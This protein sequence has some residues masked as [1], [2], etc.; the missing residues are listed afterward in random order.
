M[1]QPSVDPVHPYRGWVEHAAD[2]LI[3]G[4]WRRY[5]EQLL[6]LAVGGWNTLF[7][8]LVFVVLYAVGHGAVS[9]VAMIVVSWVISIANAYLGYRYVVFR[10]H[11]RVISELPR[12]SL[13]YLVSMAVNLVVLP[14]AVRTLPVNPYVVQG[15]FTVCVVVA[16]YAG[17]RYFSF[18]RRWQG[19]ASPCDDELDRGRRNLLNFGHCFGHALETV[20]GFAVPHGQAVVAGML[21]ADEV[22]VGRGLLHA[23]TAAA[24]R[25][26]LYLPVLRVRPA[27]DEA[28]AQAVVEAMKFDKKRTGSGLALV[29]VGDGLRAVR[30]DDL[31]PGEALAALAALSGLLGP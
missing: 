7:G 3:P 12:F 19:I 8:Y 31:G 16:S 6:Y 15:A 30:V 29:M 22:A 24:R 26:D 25:R 13:V 14:L 21:L 4:R 10:S 1:A 9:D 28:D 5:R 2:R 20:T 11:G 27:L 17:H 23:G 18:R